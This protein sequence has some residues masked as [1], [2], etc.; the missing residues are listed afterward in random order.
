MYLFLYNAYQARYYYWESIRLL[1]TLPYIIIMNAGW[2]IPQVRRAY[3]LLTVAIVS[4]ILQ[5]AVNPFRYPLLR[6]L[7]TL[8]GVSTLAQLILLVIMEHG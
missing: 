6:R 7:E 2:N 1:E 3:L 8:A 5:T 4:Y